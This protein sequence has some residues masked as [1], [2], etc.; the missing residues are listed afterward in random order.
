MAERRYTEDEIAR[1]FK[2]ATENPEARP[3]AT[4]LTL[5]ELQDIGR[6]VGVSPEAVAQAAARLDR[7]TP[8]IGRMPASVSRRML[9]VPLGVGRTVELPRKLTEAEWEELVVDLRTTFDAKGRLSVQGNFREWRNGQLRALVEPTQTGDRFRLQTFK[10]NARMMMA[11]GLGSMAGAALAFSLAVLEIRT[12]ADILRTSLMMAAA[13]VGIFTATAIRV[14]A[15][16]QLRRQQI[17]SVIDRL[18]S[19]IERSK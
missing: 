18:L 2:N 10:E 14:K 3:A 5:P 6:E 17:D 8:G 16:A 7:A 13:G 15:W 1:I 11:L 9:G 19:A 4:G 12:D